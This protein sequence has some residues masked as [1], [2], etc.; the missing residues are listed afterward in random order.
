LTGKIKKIAFSK[1]PTT[2]AVAIAGKPLGNTPVKIEMGKK[3][4]G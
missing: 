1:I 3:P 4:P 2:A